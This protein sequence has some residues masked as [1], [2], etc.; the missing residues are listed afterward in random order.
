LLLQFFRNCFKNAPFMYAIV[1]LL[2]ITSCSSATQVPE[3]K[4]L[5]S[6]L[7]SSELSPNLTSSDSSF[8]RPQPIAIKEESKKFLNFIPEIANGM[9]VDYNL[10]NIT[11]ADPLQNLFELENGD[12]NTCAFAFDRNRYAYIGA[13]I[14]PARIIKFDMQT[15]KRVDAIDLPAGENRDETRVAALIAINPHTIIHA[16]FTNPAVFTKIDGETMK[17]TGTLK[18]EVGQVNSKFIRG[19]TYDGKYV[20]AANYSTPS[21]IIKIDPDT[22]KQVDEVSFEGM[23]ISDVTA[24]TIVGSSIVGVSGRDDDTH[25]A[26]FRIDLTDI[27]KKPD[28]LLIPGYS[29]YYS[30]ATDGKNIY[31]GTFTE[32]M[33]V[34]K[35]DASG[36]QLQFVSAF[37]GEKEDETGNFSIVYDGK[38]VVVGTWNLDSTKKDKLI[39]LD[40]ETMARKATLTTPSKFPS[41]LMYLEPYIYTSS[42][43]P[44]GNVERL[45]F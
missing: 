34:V 11:A 9:N 27:H 20:Y 19:M 14:T 15:M 25:A 33:N 26:V 12:S 18:T 44:T 10:A 22:M 23:E 31:A 2:L 8:T 13:N 41:D 39:K 5:L 42:D 16:S 36:A 45:K 24:I 7:V 38:D 28:I 4:L 21:K 29:K 43:K 32:P 17:I 37:K 3:R 35:V 40:T 1:S 30:V 6:D